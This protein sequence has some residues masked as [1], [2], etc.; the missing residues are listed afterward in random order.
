MRGMEFP[1]PYDKI[2]RGV[3][4]FARLWDA[5]NCLRQLSG[6]RLGFLAEGDRLG[7]AC[8]REIARR[9]RK[10]AELISRNKR[11]ADPIRRQKKEIAF[12]FR[13]WLESPDIFEDWL[14]LRKR[15]PSFREI[16]QSES[17]TRCFEENSADVGKP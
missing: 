10:R 5:E 11:V 13:T 9:G 3:L 7:L 16:L 12:W 4:S 15:A 1:A 14:I 2:F 17:E 6:L 8:C